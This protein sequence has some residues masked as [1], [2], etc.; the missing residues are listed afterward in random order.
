MIDE[1]GEPRG[2]TAWQQCLAE[3]FKGLDFFRLQDMKWYL[4]LPCLLRC[5]LYLAASNLETQ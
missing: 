1:M 5:Q 4:L 3:C 2:S